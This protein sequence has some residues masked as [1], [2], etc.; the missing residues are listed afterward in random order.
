MVGNNGVEPFDELV[1]CRYLKWGDIRVMLPCRQLH[2]PRYYYYTNTT[3]KQL[4]EVG[5]SLTVT[6]LCMSGQMLGV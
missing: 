5:Y 2:R 1:I 6:S 3:I 4:L